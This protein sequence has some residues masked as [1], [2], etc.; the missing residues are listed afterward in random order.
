PEVVFTNKDKV[1]KEVKAALS[2]NATLSCEVAQ[3]KTEVKWYKDGKLLT[4]SKK[5]KVEPEGKLRRLVV[6]QVEK[7][8]AGEYSCEA[9]G[10][11][12]TFR[13]DV[14]E[15]KPAFI[16][17][18]KVQREV[19]AVL[20]GSTT[21]SCE[22]AQD[23]TEVKWYKDGKLLISSRKFKSEAAGKTRRLVIE[24]LE[25]KD[26]GEYVCEAAGQ[27][28]TFKVEATEPEAKF[29]KKGVQKEPL[30]VQEHESITL[31][32]S[33]TPETAAVKWF[34][35]G[36]EIKASKKYE[37]KSE[38]ASRTLTVNLAE[39]ADTAV[40]TCQ[41]KSDKQ[42]FKVQVKEIP[43]KFAKKLEAVNAEI[44]G[45][46]SLT[47]DVSHAKGKV[48]W[49]RNGVEIKPSKRF[50]IHE[51][52]VKRTL[53]ITG[54]RAEDEGEYS[55]ESRDDKSSIT[56]VP[57]PPRVV[58]FVTGLISVASEEGK[59]AVFKC[60]VSPSDAVVT[61]LRNGVKIE[62]S[63]KY[64]IS[65]KD[66]N[67]S[68]TITDLA[69]ED[70]AEISANAEGVESTANLRVREASVSFKKKLEPRTVEERETVTLEVELTKPAEVKWMRNS[71]VLKPSEKIEIKAEGTKHTLVVKDISFADRG[72]YCCESPDDKTQAKINV[73]M[74]QIKLVKGLQ[75]LE[76]SENGT[77][78]FEAE[79]S[80]ED[81]EGVWQKDGV[82]L[83][84]SPNI[85]IGVLGK[86][87]SLTL[88]SVTLEDAGLI[89]FKA[90][91]IHSSGRLTVTELPAR[92]SKPLV[93]I[94]ITQKEK[95][96]FEC[97]LSRPNVDVKWFK[98]GKELRQSKKVGIVSQGTK[99]SLII[100]KCEYE[101]QG[102]Y[103]C[104]AAEDK[105]SATLKV[106]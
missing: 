77:V 96:T 60:T 2:E 103:T 7:K 27:K 21:L 6:G 40:Y 54:I 37:I 87:H 75:S 61:W 47:C 35:D 42:E 29:E 85:I 12:L 50:Q 95:V 65:Q 14:T 70:A 99:R 24:Q 76:V 97:E 49:R 73:E 101:D 104:E 23:A 52:G 106:H 63:K 28:L 72:F 16:N 81:V 41:T 57:K 10:Q 5:F 71:I 64:V 20:T 80:H 13:L 32:T 4:S 38:G 18:E 3:E 89:S 86:K 45:S 55:C 22:V 92:I 36:T 11:K 67:H 79:V 15:P 17:Q 43:V 66:S 91:G 74:R 93:D 46:V 1:Q 56:I 69:L 31:T 34:K 19:K 33:V 82:R 90:D 58:K 44:G 53:T 83:K 25:K 98:D 62:A 30:I 51:E 68:L 48:V 26:A 102:T 59:E 8:D 100:H 39:S 94:D 84:P 88:S 9:A 105:T 78:T